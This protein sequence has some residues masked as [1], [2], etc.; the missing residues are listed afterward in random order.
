MR[1]TTALFDNYKEI[2]EYESIYT[3]FVFFF[4]LVCSS[5]HCSLSVNVELFLT[6]VQETQ[7]ALPRIC[8]T[9]RMIVLFVKQY[10]PNEVWRN[11]CLALL[12]GCFIAYTTTPVQTLESIGFLFLEYLSFLNRPHMTQN[13]SSGLLSGDKRG[14][15]A[16]LLDHRCGNQLHKML[17][18]CSASKTYNCCDW[19]KKQTGNYGLWYCFN[20]EHCLFYQSY[21]QTNSGLHVFA[22]I[23]KWL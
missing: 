16:A 13:A 9:P 22:P 17:Y 12:T 2:K 21:K 3:L 4:I 8:N 18:F 19:C 5:Y 11:S 1:I 15:S 14:H 6:A 23:L 20:F 7:M 10:L